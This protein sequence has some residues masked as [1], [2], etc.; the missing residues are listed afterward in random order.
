VNFTALSRVLHRHGSRSSPVNFTEFPRFHVPINSSRDGGGGIG[1][2]SGQVTEPLGEGEDLHGRALKQAYSFAKGDVHGA[3]RLERGVAE[4]GAEILRIAAEKFST[5]FGFVQADRR[6]AHA[7]VESGRVIAGGVHGEIEDA[8][9]P[10]VRIH[11]VRRVIGLAHAARRKMKKAADV[12]GQRLASRPTT[13]GVRSYLD[14]ALE[15]GGVDPAAVHHG[16]TLYASHRDVVLA[17]LTGRADVGLTSV[18][19]AHRAGLHCLPLAE[20]NYT[21]C[22]KA[23]ALATDAGRALIRTLQSPEA[24]RQLGETPGY[25]ATDVASLRV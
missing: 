11:V 21:L 1:G 24:K 10:V 17:L 23:S 4:D 25:D 15:R 20:E 7:L 22:M 14:H 3:E 5:V 18:A 9:D 12:Q 6:T 2:A 19:W 16:A 13:A 8:E